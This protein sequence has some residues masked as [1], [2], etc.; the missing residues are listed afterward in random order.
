MLIFN[1]YLFFLSK[2]AVV[3]SKNIMEI[4]KKLYLAIG[5]IAMLAW[6]LPLN[7]ASTNV[8][9][10][11]NGDGEVTIADVNAVI[12]VIMGDDDNPA[13]D[14]NNDG[15]VNIA[16]INTVIDII[17]GHNTPGIE[18]FTVNGVTFNMVFVEGGTFT[19]GATPEQGSD[20]HDKEKPAHD[21]TLSSYCIGETEVT[22]AL[23][24]AVMGDNPS[25]T[26]YSGDLQHPVIRVSWYD[27]QN[28][29]SKLNEITGKTFRLP[30]EAEW[31]YAAR[32]GNK[33][34]GYK[35]AGSNQVSNVA[36]CGANSNTMIHPVATK[37]PNELGLYD[38]S[39]NVFEWCQDIYGPYSSDTQIDP[40]GPTT[41]SARIFRGGCWLDSYW[42]CRVSCR[43][44]NGPY[45]N[46][47]C[48]G[49]RLAL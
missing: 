22:Q 37:A 27:C 29:I 7:A 39:G 38:M 32:G 45:I 30:T 14:V 42:Y 2:F 31:E 41:G 26:P 47:D 12:D 15:E 21:V 49:L 28:F 13:A 23:W 34:K 24:V 25:P 6:F 5:I 35:Y 1:L 43:E 4:I 11:V 3:K 44:S 40:A 48:L 46:N 16:D 18:T 9:G 17:L 36:W 10:D 20:A 33:S 19:M 8:Y